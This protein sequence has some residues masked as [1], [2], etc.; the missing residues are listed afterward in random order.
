[1]QHPLRRFIQSGLSYFG[2]SVN[3]SSKSALAVQKQLLSQ[4]QRPVI[5]D[6]GANV[7]KMTKEY[8]RA[9]PS[10]VIHAFE[11]FPASFASLREHAAIGTNTFAHQLA[12][13]NRAGI[14]L[15]N[16]NVKAETNSLLATDPRYTD[17]WESG[18]LETQEQI[19]VQTGM[20]DGFCSEHAIPAIDLLK[21][22][23][24]GA[25]M[26]ALDGAKAMLSRQAISLIYMEII[27]ASA[28]QGQPAL[29][30]YLDYMH[31][32]NYHLFDFYNQSRRDLQLV[33]VDALFVSSS[34][35]SELPRSSRPK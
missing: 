16:C 26:L 34:F 19:E 6:V 17:A 25:E 12:L 30:D 24:Q 13:T 15:F 31:G 10:A 8:R 23:I 2:Y 21:M 14:C 27:I 11:P 7:G 3:R 29:S 9:F 35:S 18:W 28:Y 20:I 33:E 5:F 32:I 22:D 1:M 4:R